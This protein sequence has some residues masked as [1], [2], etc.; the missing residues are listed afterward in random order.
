VILR[1]LASNSEPIHICVWF[2]THSYVEFV[3]HLY[4]HGAHDSSVYVV[5]DIES[6]S[7][8]YR[9]HDYAVRGTSES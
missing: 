5:R 4:V 1:A 7:R 9:S 8:S 3:A 2:V 6:T